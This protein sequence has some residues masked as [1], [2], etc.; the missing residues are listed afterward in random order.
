M[1][2][3]PITLAAISRSFTGSRQRQSI[4]SRPTAT[5]RIAPALPTL[6]SV[7]HPAMFAIWIVR[8]KS[9]PP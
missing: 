5:P 2:R 7:S 8:E 6:Q 3:V 9:P 1:L 4:P